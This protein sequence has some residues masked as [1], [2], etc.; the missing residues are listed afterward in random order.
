MKK[1]K[2]SNI[3]TQSASN[4]ECPVI[5]PACEGKLIIRHLKCESCG[6]DVN[7]EFEQPLLSKLSPD[8]QRYIIDFIKLNGS[9]KDM[10]D[11]LNVSYPTVRNKFDEIIKVLKKEDR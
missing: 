1:E 2:K 7:G 9:L 5:C 11:H 4:A 3:K 10:A 6:T 8:D